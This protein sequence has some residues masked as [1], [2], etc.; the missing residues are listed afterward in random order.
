MSDVYTELA[1]TL[2]DT[3]IESVR[4]TNLQAI[5]DWIVSLVPEVD[6]NGPVINALLLMPLA[7]RQTVQ[8]QILRVMRDYSLLSAIPVDTI[9]DETLRS[10]IRLMQAEEYGVTA[11]D[12]LRATGLLKISTRSDSV[13]LASG[14]VFSS[15]GGAAVTTQPWILRANSV[16]SSTGVISLTLR[17][18][19][20]S[21]LVP[22]QMRD[23]GVAG[24]VPAGTVFSAATGVVP[25][26][27]SIV[28]ATAFVGGA[29]AADPA[30]MAAA[31]FDN[32]VYQSPGSRDQLVSLLRSRT[33]LGNIHQIGVV[34]YGDEEMLRDK[35][36]LIPG[37]GG[38]VDLYIA[39]KSAPGELQMPLTATPVS[40]ETAGSQTYTIAVG[41]DVAPGFLDVLSV[42]DASGNDWVIKEVTRG[43][44]MSAILKEQVP[45]VAKYEHGTLSRFQTA[46]LLVESP[47]RV[48]SPSETTTQAVSV[49]FSYQPGLAAIQRAVSTR[50]GRYPGGDTLVRAA[51]PVA[52]SMSLHVQIQAGFTVPEATQ[53]RQAIIAEIS[54]QPLRPGISLSDIV[55]AL[56]P[57]LRASITIT[58]VD[59]TATYVDTFGARQMLTAADQLLLPNEPT[60]QLTA[61]TMAMYTTADRIQF[62]LASLMTPEV[63]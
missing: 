10:S 48:Y 63:P 26:I 9:V 41:R 58:R 17:D 29:E 54:R 35:R 49:T 36:N 15:A 21:A 3:D 56:S 31:I 59:F 30:V 13:I 22:V 5:R 53:M 18:N 52:L 6:P 44:D 46:T 12:G 42:V 28:A 2:T 50:E 20:Y 43:V 7:E 8:E 37:G 51:I 14:T 1:A 16:D 39:S 24:N 25:N 11:A 57:Y 61:R 62:R 55:V 27:V 32:R 45:Q 4:S 60:K 40:R 47:N 38:K 33:D 34:G 19:V 23:V